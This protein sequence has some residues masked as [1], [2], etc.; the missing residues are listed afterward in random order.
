MSDDAATLEL[1][2]RIGQMIL[3]LKM[4]MMATFVAGVVV[5]WLWIKTEKNEAGISQNRQRLSENQPVIDSF[6]SVLSRAR[7]WERHIDKG[8]ILVISPAYLEELERER[9]SEPIE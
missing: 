8:N 2:E 4:S 6:K 3:W 9:Q 7:W 1:G 5:L